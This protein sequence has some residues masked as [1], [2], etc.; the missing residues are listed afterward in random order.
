MDEPAQLFAVQH[1]ADRF[2]RFARHDKVGVVQ[3]QLGHLRSGE[4]DEPD[5]RAP[6]A[7]IV[8]P[9]RFVPVVDE[10]REDESDVTLC[11]RV[12]R[13]PRIVPLRGG[14]RGQIG[15]LHGG[16]RMQPPLDHAHHRRRFRERAQA[17]S[18]PAGDRVLAYES[19][20][21]FQVRQHYAHDRLP[22]EV[23]SDKRS[24]DAPGAT[25][26]CERS[27]EVAQFN[28]RAVGRGE[29]STCRGLRKT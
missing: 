27:A 8:G 28:V 17:R 1:P 16:R 29:Q 26:M 22:S 4:P 7:Q 15:H 6:P 13:P 19:I 14:E 2:F 24:P 18:V 10:R 5:P 11:K 12:G 21:A 9:G 3:E 20:R 23:P 25:L